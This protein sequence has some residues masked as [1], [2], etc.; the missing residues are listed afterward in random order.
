MEPLRI[1]P[2]L[3]ITEERE[4]F[5]LQGRLVCPCGHDAFSLHH[6]G[7]QTK[8][9]LSSYLAFLD[10]QLAIK[11]TC[12]ACG[13][14]I[15]VF[16]STKDGEQAKPAKGPAHFQELMLPK[17][18]GRS[19]ELI[20]SFN[21]EENAYKTNRFQDIFIDACNANTTKPIRLWG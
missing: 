11:A 19:W 13:E 21:F 15:L 18:P 2:Y 12:T 14:E 1:L 20:L 8:G 7:K 3:R 10:R 6:T 4:C 9:I 17:Y 5:A 16:D